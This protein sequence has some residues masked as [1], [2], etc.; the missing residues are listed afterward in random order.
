[1]NGKNIATIIGNLA[2]DPECRYTHSGT[3]VC[4]LRVITNE[5]YTNRDGEVVEKVTGHNVVVF[6]KAAESCATHLGK[7]ARVRVQ[8]R[9]QHRSY[10]DKQGARQYV[11]EVVTSKVT[12]LG[13]GAGSVNEVTLRGNL[14]GDLTL[15]HTGAG[16]PVTNLRLATNATYTSDGERV[17]QTTWH[18]VV[19]F[20]KLAQNC[21]D[22]LARGSA[23]S[24]EGKMRT[25]T[26]TDG[27]GNARER[28]E[29]VANQVDFLSTPAHTRAA[30]LAASEQASGEA[31]GE[32]IPF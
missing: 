8:G 17:T 3:P 18:D 19:V 25:R 7:G 23:V 15:R 9:I 16:T 20:G 27:E 2:H 21:V 14:G 5:R 4:N 29:V 31:I 13:E 32:E 26:F 11:S 12:F 6:G 1:M 22:H 24:L 10:A 28:F 30:E